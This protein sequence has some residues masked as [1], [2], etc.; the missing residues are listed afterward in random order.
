MVT[1]K[2]DKGLINISGDVLTTLVG[3]AATNCFGVRGM[4]M[5]SV[6]DGL[7]HLLR[8]EAMS[9]GVY[10][11]Y[12]DDSTISIELH[13]VIRNGV[14][15]PVICDSIMSEVRY[16]VSEYTDVEIRSVDIFVDAV[17]KD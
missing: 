4:A 8:L 16:K 17:T 6:S 11:T 2:N 14:N 3:A 5:R 1:F 12:H 13:I 7:V 9:K 10:I 15:I